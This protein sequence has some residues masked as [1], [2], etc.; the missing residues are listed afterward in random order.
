MFDL[1]SGNNT[2]EYINNSGEVSEANSPFS[3]NSPYS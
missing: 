1:E 2:P 3:M